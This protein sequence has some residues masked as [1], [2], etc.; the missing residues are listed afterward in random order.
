V[1]APK[2]TQNRLVHGLYAMKRS[3]SQAGYNA[4]DRRTSVGKA[5]DKWRAELIADL[6]G[7]VSTQQ[8]AI[9]DLASKSKLL[10]DSIDA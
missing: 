10:L 7:D 5:L 4:I 8:S 3:L 1:P 6:G 9:I 2:G